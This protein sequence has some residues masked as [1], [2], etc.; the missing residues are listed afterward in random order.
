MPE[1]NAKSVDKITR[2]IPYF[3]SNIINII[4]INIDVKEN[5]SKNGNKFHD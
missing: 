3:S 4:Q 1:F 5:L 2:K